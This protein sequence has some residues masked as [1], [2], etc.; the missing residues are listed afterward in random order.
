MKKLYILT[1]ATGHLGSVLLER[2]GREDADIRVFVL[3]GEEKKIREGVQVVTGDICNEAEL[4]P[5]FDRDGYDE[6]TLIH[7]AAKITI[8]SGRDKSVR[9]TNVKG[10]RNVMR[11]AFKNGVDR[12]VY[13]SSVHAIPEK[14]K[15]A[16]ITETDKFS[17]DTVVGQ[18]A[19]SK[20]EAAALVLQ[21]AEHGLNV[22]LV[23]PSGIIGPGD[24]DG[25]NHSV[26]TL[27]AMASGAIPTAID[28]G[29]DFVD[30]RDVAEGIILCEK[31][32][33][34]GECYILSGHYITIE[35]MLRIVKR[36]QGKTYRG[37][38]LPSFFAKAFAPATEF[39]SLKFGSGKPL[40]TPYSVYTLKA[41]GFFSHEK[42]DRELGYCV[43]DIEESIEDSL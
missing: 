8:M 38:T 16:V 24:P 33:K 21:Y 31:N 9:K 32:G 29:Y 26:R 2:L 42:A 43:R 39:F 28:G 10:T 35:E 12:V 13:I 22:S 5:F 19:K 18:Y 4:L 7:A 41:N 1:G 34:A 11:A 3:P 30:V 27:R 37:V 20:A 15:P 40:L 14:E 17:P 23:Q 36:I 6:V 25:N